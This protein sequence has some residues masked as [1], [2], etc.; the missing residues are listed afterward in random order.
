MSSTS[1]TSTNTSESESGLRRIA[2]W[3]PEDALAEIAE[4]RSRPA[5]DGETHQQ[6]ARRLMEESLPQVTKGLIFTAVHSTNDRIR[7]D[8]QKY[9]VDR[10]LG[11]PGED[12]SKKG[13]SSLETLFR[14]MEESAETLVKEA[15]V[16][17][18]SDSNDAM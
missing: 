18:A 3:I 9:L 17:R 11:K 13:L 16:R 14:N 5:V 4:E 2:S 8:A 1:S 6:Y 7:L 12:A 15:A 10:V